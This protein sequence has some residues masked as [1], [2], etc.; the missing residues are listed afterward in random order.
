MPYPFPFLVECFHHSGGDGMRRSLREAQQDDPALGGQPATERQFAKVLV[1][2]DQESALP[3]GAIENLRIGSAAHHFP[4]PDHVMP[5][6]PQ[7]LN[8]RSGEV[9]I[10]KQ[11]QIHET[12]RG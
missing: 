11:S 9:L 10:G 1:K 8:C 3:D 2:G 6:T 7:R 12:R 4:C 5:A